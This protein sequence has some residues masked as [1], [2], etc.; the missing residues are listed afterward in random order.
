MFVGWVLRLLMRLKT[1]SVFARRFVLGK[2]VAEGPATRVWRATDQASGELRA[3]KFLSPR[4]VDDPDQTV[5]VLWGV[6]ANT[7]KIEH[8]SVVVADG[9]VAADGHVAIVT[10]W[11]DGATL[12]E[13][14]RRQ[15]RRRFDYDMIRGLVTSW[16]DAMQAV[17]EVRLVHG[18]LKPTNLFLDASGELKITDFGTDAW[19]ATELGR[20]KRYGPLES[21]LPYWSPAQ[22]SAGGGS[23]WRD[24]TFAFGAIIY[25]LLTGAPPF[26]KRKIRANESA[27]MPA[28]ISRRRDR[29]AIPSEVEEVIM[30]CLEANPA[31][32]P[33][34][35]RRIRSHLDPV[36]P[37]PAVA[38]KKSEVMQ[39]AA[40]GGT[41]T[42]RTKPSR[43]RPAA[44][45]GASDRPN[46][47]ARF[48][49]PTTTGSRFGE[50]P[51][52][53][54]ARDR[55]PAGASSTLG[56]D[57]QAWYENA[58]AQSAAQKPSRHWGWL[59]KSI[60]VVVALG[61]IAVGAAFAWIVTGHDLVIPQFLTGG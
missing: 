30:V 59:L 28:L 49:V 5:R 52:P 53:A 40:I 20:R 58:L 57:D 1:G 36:L 11:I 50:A 61:L 45:N 9:A 33:S 8:P 54:P 46:G 21:S 19:L 39:P 6:I 56:R 14:R 25:E 22:I 17:E 42:A 29:I 31:H 35:F 24:D 26:S 27:A 13:K 34:S 44:G 32:R 15:P 60:L 2:C 23:F 7:R 43:D 37:I 16:A 38:R 12:T 41:P 4:L 47:H 10:P 48:S 3:I 55:E 18:A 51:A